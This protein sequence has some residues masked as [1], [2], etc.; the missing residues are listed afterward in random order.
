MQ[1]AI[2]GI[3]NVPMKSVREG[4]QIYRQTK[5]ESQMSSSSG[6]QQKQKKKEKKFRDKMQEL[7]EMESIEEMEQFR[8]ELEQEEKV[9][10]QD[11]G[12]TEK[13]RVSISRLEAMQGL[14]NQ[15]L[16]QLQRESALQKAFEQA[17][18]DG[19][20]GVAA[21]LVKQ[22]SREKQLRKNAEYIR[23]QSYYKQRITG[24]QHPY[25]SSVHPAI[26]Q[27]EYTGQGRCVPL[28]RS[29]F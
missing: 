12:Q 10:L 25:A 21:S 15:K 20:E 7:M 6:Q 23:L 28:Q 27:C 4:M 14:C 16:E 13:K 5:G 3:R 26:P 11:A 9:L 1:H 2:A 17:K 19:E 22:Y 18:K 24:G 29:S 8:M